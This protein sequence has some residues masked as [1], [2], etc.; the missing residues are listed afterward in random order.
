MQI[1]FFVFSV[2]ADVLVQVLWCGLLRLFGW[3]ALLVPAH[4]VLIAAFPSWTLFYG[5][6]GLWLGLVVLKQFRLLNRL[7]LL[8]KA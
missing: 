5:S 3:W 1:L 2:L 8:K 4:I 6:L 7:P